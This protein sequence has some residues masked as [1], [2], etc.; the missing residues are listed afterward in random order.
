MLQ[1]FYWNSYNTNGK[2]GCTKWNYLLSDTAA[3]NANFDLV[4]FPPSAQSTGG[5]GYYHTCL[6]DQGNTTATAWGPKA[7]LTQLIAALHAGNTKVIADIVIN[8]RGN[9]SSWVDFY[10]DNFG[11]YGTFQL[12][13]EHICYGDEVFT[14]PRGVAP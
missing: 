7:R 3:I 6:S 13:Q 4:W 2:Y 5:V 12:T 1:A 10:A 11:D 8:H 14:A 9:K